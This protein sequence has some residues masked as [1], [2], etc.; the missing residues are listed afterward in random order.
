MGTQ[1]PENKRTVPF[2][3]PAGTTLIAG[4]RF[5][6]NGLAAASIYC[7]GV[8]ALGQNITSSLGWPFTMVNWARDGTGIEPSTLGNIQQNQTIAVADGA[9]TAWCSSAKF[10]ANASVSGPLFFNAAALTGATM[11][12]ATIS[13]VGVLSFVATPSPSPSPTGAGLWQGAL[14]PGMVF[15][16]GRGWGAR[17]PDA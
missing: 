1:F 8:G 9:K 15:S 3:A 16:L 13:N 12:S 6:I 4:D 14:E 10:C 2:T 17:W 7:E 5:G 11:N